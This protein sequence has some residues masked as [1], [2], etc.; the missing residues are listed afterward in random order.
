MKLK[1]AVPTIAVVALVLTGA[2]LAAGGWQKVSTA[3]DSSDLTSASIF[4]SGIKNVHGLRVAVATSHAASPCARASL[5]R[6]PP[7]EPARTPLVAYC[8]W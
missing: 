1:F 4:K 2:S 5:D 6:C 8:R 7:P 3:R